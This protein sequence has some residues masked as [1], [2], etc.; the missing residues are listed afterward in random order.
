MIYISLGI[1]LFLLLFIKK[2]C[3][4]VRLCLINIQFLLCCY[5]LLVAKLVALAI[6]PISAL[7]RW[8]S[9]LH[10]SKYQ[11]HTNQLC[12]LAL[13][14]LFYSFC[15]YSVLFVPFVHSRSRYVTMWVSIFGMLFGR[16]DLEL[17][18]NLY[19]FKTV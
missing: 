8:I 15:L 12:S 1:F 17:L 18:R 2:M 6:L 3:T 4:R 9:K 5:L 16:R 19:D 7:V 13:F 11:V 14:V 10:L